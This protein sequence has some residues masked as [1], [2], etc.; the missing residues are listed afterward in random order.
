VISARLKKSFKDVNIEAAFEFN[1][2]ISVFFGPSGAGKSSI[3]NMLSGLVTPDEGEISVGGRQLFD[4]ERGINLPPEKRGAGYVFQDSRLFPHMTVL[5]NILYGTKGKAP[6]P[7][8]V[9]QVTELLGIN[10]LLTRSP[11]TLSGGE[12]Q[13]VALA[14]AM[15]SSPEFLLMDE[16][17]ASLDGPRREELIGY[18]ASVAA[19]FSI[20]VIYVTHTLEEIIRLASNVGLMSEGRLLLFGSAL[21]V[22]NSPQMMAL[23]PERDFGAIWEGRCTAAEDGLATINFGG[24]EIEVATE[25]EPGAKVRLR[26][27]ALDVLISRQTPGTTSAR[28]LFKGRVT[29]LLKHKHVA[30]ICLDIKGTPLWARITRKSAEDMNIQEN[31]EV[32]ALVKSVVASQAIYKVL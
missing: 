13:R 18:I 30:D 26:I 32:Y 12:K 20:P 9:R 22:L 19:E 2:G 27:P 21:E 5:K 17:M 1:G 23:V 25:L 14:R 16:P 28:N 6:S 29:T 24:G 8:T 7:I 31:D 15:M 4:S 10:D 11:S 3:I